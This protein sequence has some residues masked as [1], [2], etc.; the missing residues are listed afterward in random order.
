M[1]YLF[2]SHASDDKS[3]RVRPLIEAL[4]EER[5]DLW[6]DRPGHG[7]SHFG[8]SDRFIEANNIRSIRAGVPYDDA[9]REAL[10]ESGAV[11]FCL[12]KSF[13]RQRAVLEHEVVIA[14]NQKKL[15]ACIVDG[16]PYSEVPTIGLLDKKIHY[17]RIDL[18]QIS[19]ALAELEARRA[20]TSRGEAS[21]D[22]LPL[23]LW[24]AWQVV[25]KLKRDVIEVFAKNSENPLVRPTVTEWNAA[26]AQLAKIPVT[27]VLHLSDVP[28][29]LEELLSDRFGE[30][31]LARQLIQ[32]AMQLRKEVN[33]EKATE[34]Q[35]IIRRSALLPIE[36]TPPREFW[37]QTLSEAGSKSPRTLAAL[38]LAPCAPDFETMDERQ[39]IVIREFLERL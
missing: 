7:P 16:L 37:A 38:I 34:R 24:E 39:K 28:V 6:L 5:L 14:S 26:L 29:E 23:P 10:N 1:P 8:F 11:L 25:R 27:P 4:V 36:T 18:E 13:S 15:V 21:P 19:N 32:Q 9:I 31:S 35:I 30:P 17:E 20:G 22:A 3:A 33:P 12:S 2:V